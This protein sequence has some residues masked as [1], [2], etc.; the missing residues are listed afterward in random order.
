MANFPNHIFLFSFTLLIL[1]NFLILETRFFIFLT[2]IGLIFLSSCGNKLEKERICPKFDSLI[3]KCIPTTAI[4]SENPD[5]YLAEKD[6]KNDL[7]K[8]PHK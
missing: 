5:K 1:L 4:N 6:F 2:L 7:C 3:L 8:L